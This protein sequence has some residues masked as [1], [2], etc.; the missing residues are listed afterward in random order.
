MERLE[1]LFN[2]KILCFFILVIPFN[3]VSAQSAQ[4]SI[5]AAKYLKKAESLL[6]EKKLERSVIYFKKALD[7]ELK[8]YGQNHEKTIIYYDR[9]GLI[10]KNIGQ[11]EIALDYFKTF[12]N[13]AIKRYGRYHFYAGY[14]FLNIGVTYKNLFQ[15]DLAL[16]NYEK[17][18]ITFQHLRKKDMICFIYN[19][20]GIVFTKKGENTKAIEYYNK[21]IKIS[22]TLFGKNYI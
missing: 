4:D 22:V 1:Y 9:I 18:L 13:L 10:Y 6:A 5:L 15:Y 11:H 12:L 17:S 2:L 21:S 3:K 19:N 16:E 14:G 20:I 7:V 8:I